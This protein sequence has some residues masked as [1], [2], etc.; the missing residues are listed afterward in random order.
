MSAH[1]SVTLRDKIVVASR[2]T[3][4][5]LEPEVLLIYTNGPGGT[6]QCNDIAASFVLDF[7]PTNPMRHHLTNHR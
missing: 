3:A 4:R 1:G 5:G 2:A 6:M 7:D